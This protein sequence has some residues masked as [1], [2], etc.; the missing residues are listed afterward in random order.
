VPTQDDTG[1]VRPNASPCVLNPQVSGISVGMEFLTM[2]ERLVVAVEAIA[3][4]PRAPTQQDER[5]NL[6]LEAIQRFG[7]IVPTYAMLAKQ[8]GIAASTLNGMAPVRKALREARDQ[9]KARRRAGSSYRSKDGEFEAWHD[10]EDA[11]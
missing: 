1:N 8:T 5:M 3:R 10:P 4:S 9:Q 6:V 11:E 2:F 7:D